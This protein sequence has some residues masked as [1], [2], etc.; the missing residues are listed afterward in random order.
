[1]TLQLRALASVPEDQG[2]IPSTY[3]MAHSHLY[4]TPVPGGEGDLMPSLDSLETAHMVHRHILRQSMH[5]HD[6]KI[7]KNLKIEQK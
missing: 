1:M 3:T 7:N 6:I 4:K 5:T 2:S